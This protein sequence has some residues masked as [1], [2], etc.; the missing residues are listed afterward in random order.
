MTEVH[1][2]LLVIDK[3]I[4]LTSHDVVNKVR[5]LSGMRRVGHTGTLDPLA[6]GVLVLAVGR[7]T[8]LIEY[9][10]GR[11]KKYQAVIRLGQETNTYDGEG[12][13]IAERPVTVSVAQLESALGQFRGR[14]E[15]VPPMFS[16][17]K[18]DGQPLYKLARRGHT[19]ERPARPITV[20]ELKLMDWRPPEVELFVHCST[21]TYVRSLAHDLGQALGCGGH[22]IALRRL[23]VG[24]FSLSQAVPLAMLDRENWLAHLLPMDRAVDHLPAIVLPKDETQLL[25]NGQ[26]IAC[27]PGQLSGE[28][29]RVYD[30]HGRFIGLVERQG[31]DPDCHWQPHK[32][33]A[34]ATN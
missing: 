18:Q 19:L 28:I 29:V 27:H 34:P 17:I 11:T 22:L 9:V 32:I 26:Q 3:P 2:G 10:V 24:G 23:A 25:Q 16:A 14:I 7:A 31:D 30:E 15:Q 6:T 13:I 21:G 1:A 20:H 12:E 8:R 4:G 33:L 5:W